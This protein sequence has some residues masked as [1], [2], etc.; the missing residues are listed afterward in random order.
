MIKKLELYNQKK[1]LILKKELNI[2]KR[3]SI[4]SW[5]LKRK[6]K[7]KSW[8]AGIQIQ[9][10][11]CVKAKDSVFSHQNECL[12]FSLLRCILIGEALIM[13]IT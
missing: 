11:Q 7:N 6:T 9:S 10:F 5:N 13:P 12:T 2:W 3:C 4:C 8:L 1:N